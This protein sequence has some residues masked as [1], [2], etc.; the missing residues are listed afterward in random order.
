MYKRQVYNDVNAEQDAV[1]KAIADLQAAIPTE[2]PADTTDTDLTQTDTE[3]PT[4]G[5]AALT[6]GG[7]NAKTGEATPIALAV[8]AVSLVGAALFIS[9]KR[10]R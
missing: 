4:Q 6:T 9:K 2:E 3:T 7:G 1:D 5:D 8:A 10:S